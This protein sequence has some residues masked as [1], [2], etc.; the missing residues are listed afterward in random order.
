MKTA[1]LLVLC[2]VLYCGLSEAHG[3]YGQRRGNGRTT[4]RPA[5]GMENRPQRFRFRNMKKMMKHHKKN[6]GRFF[7][8][9]G[10]TMP[11]ER[12]ESNRP[13][14]GR[15]RRPFQKMKVCKSQ[16]QDNC[17]DFSTCRQTCQTSCENGRLI[18]CFNK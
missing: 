6:I 14:F 16:C 8:G 13:M 1:L 2:F 17:T 4:S 11:H 18:G 10:M 5:G 15:H 12:P 3:K 9:M 7:G